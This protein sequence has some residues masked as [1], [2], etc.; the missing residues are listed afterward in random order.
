M[1]AIAV[2]SRYA[3]LRGALRELRSENCANRRLPI[4]SYLRGIHLQH[5]GEISASLREIFHIFER[6][7]S[8]DK[9]HPIHFNLSI[10]RS[11]KSLVKQQITRSGKSLKLLERPRATVQIAAL[12]SPPL[13][14]KGI[15]RVN[16]F[17]EC[18]LSRVVR[19]PRGSP[20]NRGLFVGRNVAVSVV[21]P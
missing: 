5:L 7:S 18:V 9:I 20:Y 17:Y 2:K 3:Q 15:I 10:L 8:I 1:N 11:F 6:R 13:R 14:S 19:A 12:I 21:Q 16:S 4:E